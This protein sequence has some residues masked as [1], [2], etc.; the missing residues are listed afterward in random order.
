MQNWSQEENV[1]FRKRR[2][3]HDLLQHS[4]NVLLLIKFCKKSIKLAEINLLI[5]FNSLAC[6][7][8]IALKKII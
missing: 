7:Q 5:S 6:K 4:K 1:I 8:Q 2:Y 3:F